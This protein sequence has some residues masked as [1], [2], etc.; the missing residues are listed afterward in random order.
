MKFA[1]V[2]PPAGRPN[3]PEPEEAPESTALA[4][5]CVVMFALGFLV[6]GS[7]PLLAFFGVLPGSDQFF[8]TA[9]RLVV[10]SVSV[11]FLGAGLYMMHGLLSR[12]AR[13]VAG[14][15]PHVRRILILFILAALAVPLHWWLFFGRATAGSA[16]AL[17]LPGGFVLFPRIRVPLEFLLAKF[18]VGL[19]ALLLDLVLVSELFGLGW[20]WWSDS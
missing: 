8:G 20:F 17:V 12:A 6:A 5:G 9:P 15:L 3:P 14:R 13:P 16:T 2:S 7:A 19:L 1:R 18:V 10:L 11:A 4:W